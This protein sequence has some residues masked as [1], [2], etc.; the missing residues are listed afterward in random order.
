[1]ETILVLIAVFSSILLILVVLIQPGKSE[2]ISGM[3]GIGG[4]FSNMFG[5]RQSRNFLQ[6]L[7]IGLTATIM[8]ISIL[9]N[10]VFLTDSGSGERAP[11]SQGASVPAG[12]TGPPTQSAPV[13]TPAPAPNTPP[14]NGQ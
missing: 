11:V 12:P 5:V 8:L 6:N 1:M 7:T 14:A 4:Q 3:G 10:K 13:N 2:M 9:V